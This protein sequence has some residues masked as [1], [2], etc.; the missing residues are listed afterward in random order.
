MKSIRVLRNG[1][2]A[3]GLMTFAWTTGAQ[4]AQQPQKV[5]TGSQSA[6]AQPADA[7]AVRLDPLPASTLNADGS[8]G[9]VVLDGDTS[10]TGS[11]VVIRSKTATKPYIVLQPAGTAGLV[12]APAPGQERFFVQNDGN[13]GVGTLGPSAKLHINGGPIPLRVVG[14]SAFGAAFSDIGMKYPLTDGLL[15]EMNGNSTIEVSDLQIGWTGSPILRSRT[16][17]LILSAPPNR[18]VII[19]DAGAAT[20]LVFA[21]NGTSSFGGGMTVAGDVVV[22]TSGQS[23][24]L[25]V[26]GTGLSTF[27]GPLDITGTL[28]VKGDIIGYRVINAIYRDVAEWVDSDQKLSDGTVVIVAPHTADQVIASS[29]AYDTRVAGVVSAEPGVLLGIPGE[30]KVKVATTGR[31]KV[32]VDATVHPIAL[33]DLL[34]SSAKPGVAMKSMPLELGGVPIHRPG[35]LIGKALEA[36]PG[37]EGEILVLLSLQ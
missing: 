14:S 3:A 13:I 28:N 4:S 5:E 20:K 32:R 21:S 31:V 16:S 26:A 30:S 9:I 10:F 27:S 36:L 29:T 15:F 22:G 19:G 35:T 25:T 24:K 12:V 6:L 17:N 18:D 11:G 33:G 37:G 23:S 34:V 1:I 7:P 2:V 8:Q